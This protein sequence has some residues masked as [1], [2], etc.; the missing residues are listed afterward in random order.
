MEARARKHKEEKTF[1]QQKGLHEA[2][3]KVGA[4][5]KL[6]FGLRKAVSHRSMLAALNRLSKHL[7]EL[8]TFVVWRYRDDGLGQDAGLHALGQEGSS[9][10]WETHY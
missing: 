4:M 5:G 6:H 8:N 3:L 7:W 2:V 10:R 9:H 1:H